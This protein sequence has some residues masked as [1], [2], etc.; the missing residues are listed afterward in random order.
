MQQWP[1]I[2]ISPVPCQHVKPSNLYI[3]AS[4]AVWLYSPRREKR[5]KDTSNSENIRGSSFKNHRS[6]F[7]KRIEESRLFVDLEDL[8]LD[9]LVQCQIIQTSRSHPFNKRPVDMKN[10]HLD[11]L[12]FRRCKAQRF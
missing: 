8:D 11:Q 3:N 5:L 12:V 10:A 6:C 4:P 1:R 9:Q 7:L 2:R